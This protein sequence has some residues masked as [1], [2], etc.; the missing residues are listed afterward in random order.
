MNLPIFL[1]RFIDDVIILHWYDIAEKKDG[2]RLLNNRF[3]IENSGL[4]KRANGNRT[5]IYGTAYIFFLLLVSFVTCMVDFFL[6]L[7]YA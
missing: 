2:K 4:Y 5:F 1:K 3:Q 7:H 6:L